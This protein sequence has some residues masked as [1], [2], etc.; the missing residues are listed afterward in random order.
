M[1]E[2]GWDGQLSYYVLWKTS[3]WE[4]GKK[5]EYTLEENNETSGRTNIAQLT[6]LLD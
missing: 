6:T 5:Y 1:K 2:V 4:A 3:I